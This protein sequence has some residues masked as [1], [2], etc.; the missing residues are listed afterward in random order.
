MKTIVITGGAS[1]IGG[2][3]TKHYISKGNKVKVVGHNLNSYQ[4]LITKFDQK[5]IELISFIQADLSL[6][7]EN[8][9]VVKI[10]SD[11]N[12][13]IDKL[14]L[15]ATK[16]YI[17]YTTTTENIEASFSLDY[18]SRYTLSYG[19]TP[20]INL[21]TD[22]QIINLCGTGYKGAVDFDDIEHEGDYKPMDVMMHGS[23]LN[24]LLAIKYSKS[25]PQI[26]YMLINPGP[27]S[28]DGMKHFYN[29]KFK[30]TL[31][32]LISK[33]PEQVAI[34]LDEQINDN[35]TNSLVALSGGKLKDLSKTNK[36]YNQ[37]Q[38]LFELTQDYL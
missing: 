24:E 32:K 30:W 23:R 18:L 9:R 10:L 4:K 34:R 2:A 35:K 14:I 11:I 5:Q 22:K 21:S 8:K 27:V 1:G 6:V 33:T 15:C 19:L 28:T 3:L 13:P 12:Q 31:Y 37:D 26:N 29:S 20:L 7:K 16:H 17:S 38:Q 25:N 36:S